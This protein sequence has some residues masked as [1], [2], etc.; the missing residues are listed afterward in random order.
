M[1]TRLLI[2][3][4]FSIFSHVVL[5]GE[6][7]K[8]PPASKLNVKPVKPILDT[9]VKRKFR[10]RLREAATEIP[11]F[12]GHYHVSYW[13]CGLN[14]IVWS[15]INLANGKVWMIDGQGTNSCW[16]FNATE[17]PPEDMPEWLEFFLTSSL[18]YVYDCNP[19]SVTPEYPSA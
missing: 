1:I 13:G 2:I 16:A 11:N 12:N 8:Y 6:F 10:T 18:L 3:F 9:K 14:C 7:D 15:V 4:A 5:A 19:E 17:P